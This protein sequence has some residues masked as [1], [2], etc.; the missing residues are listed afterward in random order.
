M[1]HETVPSTDRRRSKKSFCPREIFSGV[2][3]L[4]GGT[5]SRVSSTG[6]PTCRSDFGCAKGSVSAV[7]GCFELSFLA[8]RSQPKINE[9]IPATITPRIKMRFTRKRSLRCAPIFIEADISSGAPRLHFDACFFFKC[10]NYGGGVFFAE[11]KGDGRF[12]I[13]LDDTQRRRG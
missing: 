9:A 10:S 4:S 3:G 1:L 5:A 7:D 13:F 6:T 11:P 12:K 2:C 8:E